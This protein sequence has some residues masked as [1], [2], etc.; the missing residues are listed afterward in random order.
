MNG[1]FFL[2]GIDTSFLRQ[3]KAGDAIRVSRVSGPAEQIRRVKVVQ[4]DTTL[5]LTEPFSTSFEDVCTF[6]RFRES[7]E[8]TWDAGFAVASILDGTPMKIWDSNVDDLRSQDA[9][10]NQFLWDS[11]QRA[12]S[13]SHPSRMGGMPAVET[14]QQWVKAGE[15]LKDKLDEIDGRLYPLLRWV[16]CSMRGHLR[17]VDET[18]EYYIPQLNEMRQFV[19]L[20][21]K[22]ETEAK[23]RELAKTN[24]TAFGYHGSPVH[25]WHSILH[26][27]LNFEKTTHGRAHGNGIYLATHAGTSLGYLNRR[28]KPK[29]HRKGAALF[30][31]I[32][33]IKSKQKDTDLWGGRSIFGD[34]F[35]CLAVCEVIYR[36]EEFISKHPHWSA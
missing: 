16:L 22:P 26:D 7:D 35:D 10:T 36:P 28:P 21:S 9:Q 33:L 23:F 29:V 24:R 17:F 18:D 34:S 8:A 14:M 11:T 20:C 1:E 2:T 27:G 30:D 31:Q 3:F 5:R 25:N 12:E 32:K 6:H 19:L 13:T 4:S 15:R